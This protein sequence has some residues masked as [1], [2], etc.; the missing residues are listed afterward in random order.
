[1]WARAELGRGY[2]GVQVHTAVRRLH[3]GVMRAPEWWASGYGLLVTPTVQQPTPRFEDL[4]GER[5]GTAFGLFTMP[6][7]VTGQPAIS[8]PLGRTSD[9]LPLGVQFVADYGRE[10]LLIRV[11]SQLE[12]ARP[13]SRLVPPI[14]A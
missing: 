5:V 2:S 14:H 12:E 1:V 7:S 6:W 4:T 13:W 9:G 8:L 11:A 10:D 3:S